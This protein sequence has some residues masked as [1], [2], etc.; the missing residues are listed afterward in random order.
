MG[1][2]DTWTKMGSLWIFPLFSKLLSDSAHWGVFQGEKSDIYNWCWSSTFIAGEISTFPSSLV[3][4]GAP[5]GVEELRGDGFILWVP[6]A[7]IPPLG[8]AHFLTWWIFHAPL[9]GRLCSVCSSAAL[10]SSFPTSTIPCGIIKQPNFSFFFPLPKS[11][12]F[13]FPQNF[14][15]VVPW[16]EPH[17]E[18]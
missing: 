17:W 4:S 10:N 1:N 11:L 8:A 16:L 14:F 3:K 7:A 12:F 6:R 13:F 18:L 2:I 15:P 5:W 9:A